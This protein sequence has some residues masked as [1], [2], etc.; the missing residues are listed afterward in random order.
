MSALHDGVKLEGLMVYLGEILRRRRVE[1]LS[2]K[3]EE[4]NSQEDHAAVLA[5]KRCVA[6]PHVR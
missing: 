5:A 2:R 3:T 4:R 1:N 6:D